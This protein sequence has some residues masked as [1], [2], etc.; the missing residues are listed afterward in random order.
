MQHDNPSGLQ[1]MEIKDPKSCPHARVVDTLLRE[2]PPLSQ[3]PSFVVICLPRVCLTS[4]ESGLLGYDSYWE[5]NLSQ[6]LEELIQ[7]HPK[8]QAASS[9]IIT[10]THY[11]WSLCW[12]DSFDFKYIR[13]L[14]R[15]V[16]KKK[17]RK[18]S[19]QHVE[20]S[21]REEASDVGWTQG[22]APTSCLLC[23]PLLGV[24]A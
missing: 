10:S 1:S 11:F 7:C 18:L 9:S 23:F 15:N 12:L 2:L 21:Q 20:K 3:E 6:G 16:L 22:Q 24:Q 14:I 13:H 8:Q 17:K 5:S 4:Q 19:D